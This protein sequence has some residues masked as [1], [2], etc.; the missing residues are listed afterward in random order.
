MIYG[1]RA[2]TLYSLF[3]RTLGPERKFYVL[4]FIYGM[5]ISLFT[6]A[7]PF[8]VQVLITT[9]TNTALMQPIIVLSLVVF[10]VLCLNGVLSGLQ[11]HLMERF[12]RRFYV[13]MVS[14]IVLRNIHADPA[15]LNF[16]RSRIAN[17]YFEIMTVQHKLP[18]LL[19]GG[20]SLLLQTV[21]GVLL[22]S[23]LSSDPARL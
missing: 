18:I 12:K 16:D 20:F 5:A 23:K 7:V 21:V 9:L 22:V 10:G 19:T 8:A 2:H 1:S 11:Y 6:L 3:A 17:R 4:T 13:R 15:Q 14:D